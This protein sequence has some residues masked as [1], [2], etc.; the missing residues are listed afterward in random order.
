MS[1]KTPDAFFAPASEVAIL[2]RADCVPG[3]VL[4]IVTIRFVGSVFIETADG[5]K[6][7]MIGGKCLTAPCTG[8][9]VPATDAHRRAIRNRELS[10]TIVAG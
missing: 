7:A 8:Y 9:A 5:R 1:N 6:F 3:V 10:A 2:P 4:E